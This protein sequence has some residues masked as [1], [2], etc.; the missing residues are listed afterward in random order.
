MKDVSEAVAEFVAT[1]ISGE[2]AGNIRL[3][4]IVAGKVEGRDGYV[5]DGVRRTRLKECQGWVEYG[6]VEGEGEGGDIVL[7]IWFNNA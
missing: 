5:R 3:Y 2:D 4:R 6:E 1:A 7:Q